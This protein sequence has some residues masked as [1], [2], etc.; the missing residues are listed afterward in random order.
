MG[1]LRRYIK[2]DFEHN[3]LRVYLAFEALF[4]WGLIFICWV[5]YPEENKY[6]IMTHTF[7][8]LGSFQSNHNP[9][10]WWLFSAAMVFWG[11]ATVPLVLYLYRRFA[12]ISIWGARAGACLLLAGCVGVV[13][14]ALFPDAHGAVIGDVEWTDIH[15]KAALLIAAGFCLGIS[16]HGILLLKDRFSRRA[17]IENTRSDY[18]RLAWPYVFWAVMVGVAAYFQ[19]K[20]EFVYADMKAAA[21]ASGERIGSHWAEALNTWYS[22]PLWENVMIGTLFVFLIWFSLVVPNEVPA[23]NRVGA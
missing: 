22:F 6:S 2:G 9:S 4:F 16:W 20:W 19:I 12:A 14:V 15:E 23:G 18:R 11:T 3:E 5:I 13:L 1:A 7:S 10:G 17:F 8:F 21:G